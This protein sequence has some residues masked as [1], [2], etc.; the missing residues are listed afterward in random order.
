MMRVISL[1]ITQR[2]GLS[3]DRTRIAAVMDASMKN[4][5]SLVE[6]LD[7]GQPSVHLR[8]KSQMPKAVSA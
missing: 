7:C 6:M 3:V 4:R 8:A 5:R 2:A 1:L